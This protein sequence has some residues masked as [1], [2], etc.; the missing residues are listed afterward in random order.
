MLTSITRWSIGVLL[1]VL[2]LAGCVDKYAPD[3]IANPSSFLVVDGSINAAGITSIRLTRTVALQHKGAAPAEAQAS[4]YIEEEGGRRYPLSEA[5]PGTYRSANLTLPTGTKVR[6]RIRTGREQEYGSD[7]VAVKTTPPID[8]VTWRVAANKVLLYVHAHDDTRQARYYRWTYD[9][10]WQFR[11]AFDSYWELKNGRMQLRTEDIFNCWGN[12]S[13]S[14]VR[15]TNTLKLDQ[16]V[17]SA[18]PLTF[19]LST[20]KKLPIKYS[21]LV[22]QY[23]LTAEEYAYWEEIRKTTENIGGL[24]D[25]LP[26]QVTGNVHNLSDPDEVVLGFVGAQSVTQQRIFIDNKQLP[27]IMPT[28]RAI[29]GYEPD[30][31]GL[32]VYPSGA[33]KVPLLTFFK[34]TMFTPVDQIDNSGQV[35]SYSHTECVDCRVRGTNVKPAFWP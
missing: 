33:S 8:S 28:W 10:T 32:A 29:T 26:T 14:T 34:N 2:L 3:V 24:Y 6:L 35:F 18:Y 19:L 31:C 23:A 7:F 4:V 13:S 1:P 20:S 27:Q 30:V 16:D 12:E 11:S 25:P 21:I 9:E 17:V 22:R 5:Q 15:L